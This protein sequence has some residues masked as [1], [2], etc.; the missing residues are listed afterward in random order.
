MVRHPQMFCP[1]FWRN[2][3]LQSGCKGHVD[4]V[5]VHPFCVHIDGD[6]PATG[7]NSVKYGFPKVI[8]SLVH[9]TFAMYPKSD[10]TNGRTG[11]Q[12]FAN[13]ITAIGG[14]G[15]GRQPFDCIIGV[16]TVEPF[17]AMHPESQLKFHPTR[18]SL[19]TN[20]FEHF[21]VVVAFLV[22]KLWHPDIVAR[23]R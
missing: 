21:K 2:G 14:M 22:G 10:P 15:F 17:I 8:T 20:V 7:G 11:F 23:N 6:S 4:H 12:K 16:R 1:V 9:T 3:D 18:N 13:G 19:L 5:L